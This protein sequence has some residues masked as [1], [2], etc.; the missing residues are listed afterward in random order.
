MSEITKEAIFNQF[1][2]SQEVSVDIDD[3]EEGFY[4][5]APW[6]FNQ[7]QLDLIYRMLEEVETWFIS[8]SKSIDVIVFE[9]KEIQGHVFVEK[10][11]GVPEVDDIFEKYRAIYL[12]E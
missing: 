2:W 5:I 6:S 1:K 12:G 11:C 8:R 10:I 4:E 7:A 3:S 9:F